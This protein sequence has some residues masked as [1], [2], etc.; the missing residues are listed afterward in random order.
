MIV[1]RRPQE[2]QTETAKNARLRE[3][4]R[5]AWKAA[6]ARTAYWRARMDMHSAIDRAEAWKGYSKAKLLEMHP[7][8]D[9]EIEHWMLLVACYRKALGVQLLTPAHRAADIEWKRKVL[10]AGGRK[11][12][13]V[14]DRDIENSI[15]RKRLGQERRP[16]Q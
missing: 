10:A 2:P 15:R 1:Q 5:D 3:Q 7:D 12:T 13:D 8:H 4:R 14:T 16:Q 9:D 11:Y 6:E